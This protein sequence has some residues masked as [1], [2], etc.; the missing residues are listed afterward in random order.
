MVNTSAPARKKSSQIEGVTPNPPAAFSTLTI[1]ASNFNFVLSSTILSLAK[2]LALLPTISPINSYISRRLVMSFVLVL[3][4]GFY[5]C[6]SFV[7]V[8][9]PKSIVIKKELVIF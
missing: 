2:F 1:I 8:D 6:D 4:M 3:T 9:L 7:E 5:S